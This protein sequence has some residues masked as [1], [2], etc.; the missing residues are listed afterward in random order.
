M[1]VLSHQPLLYY[2]FPEFP[3]HAHDFSGTKYNLNNWRSQGYV[4]ESLPKSSNS[5][6]FAMSMSKKGI[7]I[8]NVRF[9]NAK[10]IEIIF[11]PINQSK[12]K[13]NL[14]KA[15]FDSDID[16]NPIEISIQIISRSIEVLIGKESKAKINFSMKELN[17]FLLVVD[18]TALL[19]LFI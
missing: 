4:I 1:N 14:L 7:E 18:Q 5:N 17:H 10:S 11:Y 12:E 15:T 16:Q 2:P 13:G 19:F 8:K 3:Y 9:E 6:N